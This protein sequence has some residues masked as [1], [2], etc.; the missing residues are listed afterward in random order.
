MAYFGILILVLSAA[1]LIL[2]FL[3]KV[4]SQEEHAQHA[5]RTERRRNDAT[6]E[7]V[8]V[9]TASSAPKSSPRQA[10][11]SESSTLWGKALSDASGLLAG[12]DDAGDTPAAKTKV[13]PTKKKK[14]AAAKKPKAKSSAKKKTTAKK[15]AAKKTSPKSKTATKKPAAKKAATRKK[16]KVATKPKPKKDNSE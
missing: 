7:E 5:L 12:L 1:G 10:S 3:V 9:E 11:S 2:W 16:K 4:N 15:P 6:V 13:T 14:K 8:K